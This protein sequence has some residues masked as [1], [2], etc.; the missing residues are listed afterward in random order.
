[1]FGKFEGLGVV[2]IVCGLFGLGYSWFQSRK[3]ADVSNKLGMTIEEM[4]RSAPVDI[5][6]AF[7]ERAI[8]KSVDREVA[9]TVKEYAKSTGSQIRIDMD[10]MIRK[11]VDNVYEDIRDKVGTKVEDEVSKID[12]DEM[13]K[14]IRDRVE[15]KMF[16]ELWNITGIGKMFGGSSGSSSSFNFD[17]LMNNLYMVKSDERGE[18]LKEFARHM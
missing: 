17:K 8:E 4:S 13:K 7:V 6:K 14:G 15:A 12:I 5:Q 9:K 2:G 16:R 18:V 10:A 11:D 3:I 1:M